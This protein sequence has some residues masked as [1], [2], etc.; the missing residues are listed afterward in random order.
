MQKWEYLNATI[1]T[2]KKS[3]YVVIAL[4]KKISDIEETEI[5]SKI[6]DKLGSDG[7]ELVG[8]VPTLTSIGPVFGGYEGGLQRF[9]LFFKRPIE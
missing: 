5:L 1:G 8:V 6:L 4:S 2:K 3:G 7:W 9:D